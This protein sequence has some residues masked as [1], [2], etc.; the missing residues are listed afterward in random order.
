V[1][2]NQKYFALFL[3]LFLVVVYKTTVL[4][5]YL[6]GRPLGQ[7]SA[8]ISPSQVDTLPP[9][10]T[11]PSDAHSPNLVEENRQS[12]NTSQ[13]PSVSQPATGVRTD[14]STQP[15]TATTRQTQYP[16]DG[17]IKA[18]GEIVVDTNLLR[19]RISLLGGRITEVLLKHYLVGIEP[20]SPPLNLVEH[21]E[22]TA[23]PLGI[24]S[25]PS[26][27]TWVQYRQVSN[28]TPEAE[29]LDGAK[30][31]VLADEEEQDIEL[32]GELPDGRSIKKVLKFR[33]NNYLAQLQVSVSAPPPDHSRLEVEWS[34][35]VAKN[36]KATLDPYEF[37]GY[38]WFDG[39]K[40]SRENFTQMTSENQDLGQ[41]NWVSMA[42]KYFSV[43]LISPKD[44]SPAKIIK[45]GE[46]CWARVAGQ[47]TTAAIVLFFG[48]NSYRL[49]EEIGYEISR[50]INFGLTG[51]IS[52]PLLG[53]LHRFHALFGNYGLAIVALTIF[54][55]LAVYPLTSASFKQ[56]KAMQEIQ[57]EVQ[58]L[59]EAV[60]DKQQQQQEMLALYKKRGVNPMGGCLPIFIQMPIFI[61]LYS[62]L[63]LA[64][65]LRH[66]PF[67]FW[68]KD[69]SAPEKLMIGGV[70]VPVMVILFVITMLIQQW[71]T[72]S[73]MDPMQK[74]M[75][76]VMPIVF[77]FMFVNLPAGLT[78][79]WL[80]NNLISIGQQKALQYEG[81][82]HALAITLGVSAAV[83][84]L[85]FVWVKMGS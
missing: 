28:P 33:A 14:S 27:D 5:P 52:G 4:D 11:A 37:S 12:Q 19:T 85:A 64:V 26:D 69:L 56:M 51:F 58:R 22:Q 13:K 73:T 68:I 76:M 61:G 40:A 70:G 47:E 21:S 24:Y 15:Q 25:G 62:A 82:K 29:K 3:C 18:A 71:T 23:F 83:F 42:D 39:K 81:T 79:Y 1:N 84:L 7:Q 16:T 72:P 20:H 2:D 45:N 9:A 36:G 78:I 66:T 38:V 6:S 74:K 50:N 53:F 67:A 65:E 49:L 80:T 44:Q 8:P 63:M 55:K 17:Q 34:R 60:Q 43:S 48:P 46:I 35:F 75:M 32:V 41:V 77:G 54:V 57:P 31:F 10:Q 30:H 59:R